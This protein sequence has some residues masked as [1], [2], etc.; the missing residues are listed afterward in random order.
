MK[1]RNVY[2]GRFRGFWRQ[3]SAKKQL[4]SALTIALLLGLVVLSS[5]LVFLPRNV[6]A[7]D[8]TSSEDFEDDTA[9]SDPSESWY[10]Y[11][12]SGV[13]G[14][15]Y[16]NVTDYNSGSWTKTY[17]ID[18]TD[19]DSDKVTAYFNF[20]SSVPDWVSVDTLTNDTNSNAKF[21]L[22]N[23]T[24]SICTGF[25]FKDGSFCTWS[26]GG[27]L[28]SHFSAS[29]NT[30]YHVNFSL[31]FTTHEYKIVVDGT[32]YGW[33]DFWD[34]IDD[35]TCI[36][37]REDGISSTGDNY[38]DNITIGFEGTGGNNYPP[39]I[40]DTALQN[41][42][43][44]SRITWSGTAGSAV[45]CNSS[46]D[47]YETMNITVVDGA[48][49]NDT[50]VTEI[51]VWVGDLNDTGTTITADNIE[52]YASVDNSTWHSFGSFSSGGSNITLNDTTWTWADDPFPI[53]GNDTIYCRF[54]LSIPAG[55]TADTY[56]SAS[57]TAWKI[58]LLG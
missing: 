26:S 13:A 18:T 29:S 44:N 34:T 52:L 36:D 38:F 37:I 58:Y 56:W 16:A 28:E 54:K 1:K 25:R 32:S 40:N 21:F 23:S 11:E 24:G 33:Y 12:E 19:S 49:A 4:L 43:T 53:T 30:W 5:T 9:D 39:S 22:R 10:T 14:T 48:G 31:N 35:V 45:W 6:A 8:T 2:A 42:L 41:S 55:Q 17:H 27:T 50:N 47:G 57:A 7:L 15:P 46:G 3:V 20:T 51:R